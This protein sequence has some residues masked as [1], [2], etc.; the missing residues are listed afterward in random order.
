MSGKTVSARRLRDPAA[1]PDLLRK[2]ALRICPEYPPPPHF[3]GSPA[4]TRDILEHAAD[5]LEKHQK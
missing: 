1:L 4:E 3:F 2:L 5:E